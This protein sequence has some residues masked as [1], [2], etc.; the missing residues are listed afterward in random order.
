MRITAVLGF[1]L[2]LSFAARADFSYTT[3]AQSGGGMMAAA[4]AGHTMRH[5][6]KGDKMKVDL[7]GSATIVDLAAQTITHIDNGKKTYSVTPFSELSAQTAQVGMDVKVDVKETGQRKTIGGYECREIVMTMEAES[8]QAPQQAGGGMKMQMTTNLWVSSDVP[9]YRELRSFNQ[10]MASQP[11]WRAMAGGGKGSQASMAVLQRQV[12]SINGVPVLQV[13][14][15]G[16]AVGAAPNPQMEQQRAALEAMKQQGGQQAKMAERMLA[17][18]G[19]GG[20]VVEITTESSGFS[21]AAIPASE[22]DPPAGYQ[23][24]A[25]AH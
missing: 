6:L 10:R 4:A 11:V 20:S 23:K 19:G 18:M 13:L 14:K 17:M 12:A 15:I 2:A 16:A 24:V 1:G 7:G 3:T 21:T 8:P 25:A 9:G 22:F 5:F